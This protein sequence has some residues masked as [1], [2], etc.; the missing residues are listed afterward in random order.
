[1]MGDRYESNFAGQSQHSIAVLVERRNNDRASCS[2]QV[3]AQHFE[4]TRWSSCS[5]NMPL[6]EKT[7]FHSTPCDRRGFRDSAMLTSSPLL[8][9]NISCLGTIYVAEDAHHL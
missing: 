9:R 7:R 1:M 6:D 8:V 2:Y 5:S 4:S 3:G